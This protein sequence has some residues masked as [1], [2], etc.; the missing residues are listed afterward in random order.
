MPSKCFLVCLLK[1]TLDFSELFVRTKY[2]FFISSGVRIWWIAECIRDS[3]TRP[4]QSLALALL[5]A[6]DLQVFIIPPTSST[7]SGH[8]PNPRLSSSYAVC[9]MLHPSVAATAASRIRDSGAASRKDQASQ[10]GC[11]SGALGGATFPLYVAESNPFHASF[12][13]F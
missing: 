12:R 7:Q 3:N 10:N 5:G 6:F 13:S 11:Q 9:A 8:S 2:V 1:V 4:N